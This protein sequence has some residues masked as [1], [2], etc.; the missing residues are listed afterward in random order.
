[1]KKKDREMIKS[2]QE[3]EFKGRPVLSIPVGG[4]GYPF[5]FGMGKAM[6]IV[7]YFDSIKSFVDKFSEEE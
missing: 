1:M 7:R 3:G 6:A 5:S 4:N 2:P